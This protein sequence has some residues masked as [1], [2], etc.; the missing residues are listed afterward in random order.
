[1]TK[2][3]FVKSII[4]AIDQSPSTFEAYY[5]HPEYFKVMV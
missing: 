2:M 5:V 3:I 1:M 4:G